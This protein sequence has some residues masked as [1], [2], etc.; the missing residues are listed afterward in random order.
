MKYIPRLL[1]N[2]LLGLAKNFPAVIV[3]GARQVG[4]STWL[5]HV[6]GDTADIVVL[7]P[8]IDIE[9]ARQDPEL[10]LNNHRLPLVLDEIQYAPELVP[11]IK[12]RIDSLGK[13]GLFFITGSQQWGV[14]KSI[15]E[16]LAGRCAFIDLNGFSLFEVAE[17]ETRTNCLRYWLE[18][19]GGSIS[20]SLTRLTL[21]N[22]FYEQLWKGF[23]PRVHFLDDEFIPDYFEAYQ[24][25]YIERDVRL[26]IDVS[27]MNLFSRF[28]GLLAAMS[29][30]EIN[31]S[32]LGRDLGLNPQTAKSW[33]SVLVYTF[34]WLEL[35]PF[36]MNPIKRISGKP[37]GY[38]ADTGF[39]C[40]LLAISSPRSLSSH[41]SLGALFE[42]AAVSEL[43]KQ[44]ASM[45]NKP[46]MY[47]WRA[48]SGGEVDLIL[49]YDG[50]FYPIE[51]KVTANPSS[52]ATI[53]ISSF[54][55]HYP[56]LR[57]A[58]GLVMAPT[59]RFRQISENDYAIPWDAYVG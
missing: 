23:M 31:F 8:V 38:L 7:D 54:R 48:Y 28:V 27:D 36:T 16:S 45:S 14:M 39:A 37:K 19:P 3:T 9:N 25:T 5:E 26:M 56:N 12:R 4:K 43:K 32:E 10:F 46:K 13:N 53:G 30:Q 44:I 50:T 52:K 18:N 17:E 58:P 59:D 40:W 24:R 6:L 41:P 20:H 49:E 35:P 47:H 22:T 15:S 33:L 1:T 57:I 51:F 55:K 2:R 11:A 34:Q 29:A 21:K 42:S